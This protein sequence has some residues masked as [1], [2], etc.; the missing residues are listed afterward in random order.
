MH[1][2]PGSARGARPR[3]HGGGALCPAVASPG[4]A[5]G[6]LLAERRLRRQQQRLLHQQRQSTDLHQQHQQ[7][8]EQA[9]EWGCAQGAAPPPP[10]AL[11]PG[12]VPLPHLV[13]GTSLASQPAG[14]RRQL[15]GR[16]R[17][18]V[19]NAAA[20][21]GQP[22]AAVELPG[23]AAPSD[24]A[25]GAGAGS[26]GGDE[27]PYAAA[28]AAAARRLTARITAAPSWR[29]V[30]RAFRSAAAAAPA[31]AP[32]LNAIHVSAAAARLARL[33]PVGSE[34]RH[35]PHFVAFLSKLDG[36]VAAALSSTAAVDA[37]PGQ[38][39]AAAAEGTGQLLR[40]RQQ[41]QEQQQRKDQQ[42]NGACEQR[43]AAPEPQQL[44]TL[45]WV[46][47]RAA[48]AARAHRHPGRKRNIMLHARGASRQGSA[49]V[50]SS[51]AHPDAS[52]I[53]R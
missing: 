18:A 49:R 7:Q 3:V 30:R 43:L 36:H 53:T 33:V 40:R 4:R 42:H 50:K 5:F 25:P 51:C 29:A 45:A 31:G 46:S 13:W 28:A 20:L 11:G 38:P 14:S 17:I 2:R 35:D 22:G 47:R 23:A 41:Q 27:G 1:Q 8:H 6:L 44:A 9:C 12:A 15:L 10:A 52:T 39:A 16:S 32:A 34:Q 37:S 48:A 19:L 21:S 26:S 24:A